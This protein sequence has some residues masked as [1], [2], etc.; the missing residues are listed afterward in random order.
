MR[1][2]LGD[3]SLAESGTNSTGQIAVVQG[4]N[5]TA[6]TFSNYEI[7]IPNYTSANYKSASSDMVNETN[8]TT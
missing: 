5:T 6:N 3:G 8:A 4:G 1:R 2:L 7:Y